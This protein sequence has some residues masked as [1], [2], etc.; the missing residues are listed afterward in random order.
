MKLLVV[1]N[2]CGISGKDNT[3]YYVD[4]IKSILSQSFTDLQLVVSC[5]RNSISCQRTLLEKFGTS[6]SYNFIDD[7]LPVNVTF[8]HTVQKCIEQFGVFDGYMY[9]DSGVNFWWDETAIAQA[10]DLFQ[11]GYGMTTIQT[12]TDTGFHAWLGVASPTEN[13]IIPVGK[14]CNLHV[15]IFSEK[16]RQFYGNIIP[17]IFASYCTE[18]VFSFLNAAL[19][20]QWVILNNSVVLHHEFDNHDKPNDGDG[21][22]GHSSGFRA[23]HGTWD[24]T[25]CSPKSMAAICADQE[26]RSLGFGFE[27]IRGIL[28][29]DQSCFDH[30]QFCKNDQLKWFLKE[31]LFIKEPLFSYQAIKHNF[32]P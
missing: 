22:D 12:D 11:A 15:Q 29:H 7:V 31:N 18:S 25:F 9:V 32:I 4:A 19:R 20:L 8:N 10:W 2:T 26:G 14:A 3:A 1:Y 23:P 13:F 17:D 5:C 21:L 24:H 27:E 28:I 16:L 30:N 6:I